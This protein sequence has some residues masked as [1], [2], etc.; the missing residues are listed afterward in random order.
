MRDQTRQDARQRVI[1]AFCSMGVCEDLL[2]GFCPK[3]DSDTAKCRKLTNY[4]KAYDNE[5]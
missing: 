2:H 1:G 3:M 5:A 4:L